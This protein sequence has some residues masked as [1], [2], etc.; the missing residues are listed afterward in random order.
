MTCTVAMAT[1]LT[2]L[3]GNLLGQS[4]DCGF[5]QAWETLRI[6]LVVPAEGNR[7]LETVGPNVNDLMP[8]LSEKGI[9]IAGFARSAPDYPPYPGTPKRL[10]EEDLARTSNSAR[11]YVNAWSENMTQYGTSGFMGSSTIG[12]MLVD[13]REGYMYEG[14]NC[15]YGDPANHAIHGP[16]TD[17]VFACGN[18]FVNS[19]LKVKVESG[20]GAGYDRAKRVWEMLIDRQYDC[21]VMEDPPHKGAENQPY[22]GAGISLPYF[23]SIFRDH[24][25]LSPAEGRLSSYVPE[26]RGKK[27]V[28]IHGMVWYTKSAAICS[29]VEDHT[30]LFS[31]LWM[32]FGQPCLAPFLPVYIGVNSV[33]EGIDATSNPV[34]RV[35]EDL[36]LALEFRP[37]YAEK[38]RKFWT[39]FEIQTIEQSY[40]VESAA[41]VPAA[42]GDVAGARA[43][44]TDFV[45]QKWA[46]A[47][48]LGKQ[49]VQTLQDLPLSS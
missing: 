4:H 44:L 49:W 28:C 42:K 15:V 13:A 24:G 10:T 7:Y 45:N 41:G 9:G 19:K 40:K 6:R 14:A 27:A 38:I 20:I 8:I 37:A 32:T 16:M 3:R 34:A 21:C 22:Y 31:C 43:L 2:S 17:Q 26:E 48:S 47:T 36:R 12:R 18:F 33:P 39:V 46:E 23:M 30:N 11:Q 35:F 5:H 1:G 29:L 25:D